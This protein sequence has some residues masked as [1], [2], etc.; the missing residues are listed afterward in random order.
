MADR[1]RALDAGQGLKLRFIFRLRAGQPLL[2]MRLFA[3]SFRQDGLAVPVPEA[4][5]QHR[6]LASLPAAVIHEACA[7]EDCLVLGTPACKF[8]GFSASH[9]GLAHFGNNNWN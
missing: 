4:Q 9:L 7:F 5:S 1:E 8:R 2:S 6:I 3:I